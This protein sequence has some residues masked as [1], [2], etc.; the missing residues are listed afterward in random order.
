M[1]NTPAET[2]AGQQADTLLGDTSAPFY[3]IGQVA[4]LLGIQPAALRRLDDQ[5][6]VSPERSEGGQRRYSQD[7]VEQLRQVMALTEEGVTLP[8]VRKV[9]EL[10]QQVEQLREEV[11]ELR[12]EETESP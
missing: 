10:Q 12:G 2:R 11:A 6:I 5:E 1:N 9:M 4:E 8:G 3:T 7:E